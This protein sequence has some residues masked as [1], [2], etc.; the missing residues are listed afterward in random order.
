MD[1]PLNM[2]MGKVMPATRSGKVFH[3]D[4]AEAVGKFKFVDALEMMRKDF[5]AASADALETEMVSR[6]DIA[7]AGEILRTA[8]QTKRFKH[9]AT[10]KPIATTILAGAVARWAHK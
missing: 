3:S 5:E 8:A 6:A 7:A 10:A 1:L 4:A 9:P 2:H